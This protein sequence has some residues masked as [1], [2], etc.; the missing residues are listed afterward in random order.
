MSELSELYSSLLRRKDENQ[1]SEAGLTFLA[2]TEK[3]LIDEELLPAVGESVLS[4]LHDLQS[5]LRLEV[6]YDPQQGVSVRQMGDNVP[7][8]A[9]PPAAPPEPEPAGSAS[10]DP[11]E[12]PRIRRLRVTFPDGRRIYHKNAIRVLVQTLTRIGL[13]RVAAAAGDIRHA[14]YPLVSRT[15][16]TDGSA[17]W[18]EP[19]ADGW[20]VYVNTNTLVKAHDLRRLSDKL[21]LGLLVETGYWK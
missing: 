11:P 13:E 21:G 12:Q 20:Y 6:V 3:R 9:P 15:R 5:R 19:A 16:R 7:P 17:K 14:G 1:L 8:L 10:A 2:E 4:V 18:Q